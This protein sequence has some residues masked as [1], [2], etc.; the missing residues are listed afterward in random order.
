MDVTSSTVA[1][2]GAII[3]E[4]LIHCLR[5]TGTSIAS[6]QPA[7]GLRGVFDIDFKDGMLCFNRLY[8]HKRHYNR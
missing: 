7:T 8:R 6:L 5:I 4:T 2:S 3:H 1:Q